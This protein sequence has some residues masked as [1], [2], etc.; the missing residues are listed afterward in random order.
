[1]G[2]LWTLKPNLDA[3][4]L[5]HTWILA[6][7]VDE[8]SSHC[9]SLDRQSGGELTEIVMLGSRII[10]WL[11]RK[12]DDCREGKVASDG[13]RKDVTMIRNIAMRPALY[14]SVSCMSAGSSIPH[15]RCTIKLARKMRVPAE[16]QYR[17][18]KPR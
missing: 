2:K 18:S 10:I 9:S 7:A 16:M 5:A 17:L 11:Q 4:A 8:V 15:P 14:T 6:L 3:A 13:F 1:M 12:Q